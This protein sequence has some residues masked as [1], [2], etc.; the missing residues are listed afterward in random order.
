[1]VAASI[2]SVSG[3]TSIAGRIGMGAIADRMGVRRMLVAALALQGGMIFWLLGARTAWSFYVFAIFFGIAYGGVMPLYAVLA[4][5]HYSEDVMGR[6][7]GGILFGA[8]MGMALGGFLGG[9][10]FDAEGSYALAYILSFVIGVIAV[11]IA[12]L[13]KSPTRPRAEIQKT[14]IPAL[15]HES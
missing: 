15:S 4:R 2:L 5:E 8:T 14:F 9:V 11:V 10:I 6:I 1:M 13:L 7:Y 3:G 12:A